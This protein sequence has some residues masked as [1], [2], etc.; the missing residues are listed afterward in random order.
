MS[1]ATPKSKPG[2]SSYSGT[3]KTSSELLRELEELSE[4]T[5]ARRAIRDAFYWITKCTATKDE[6]DLVANPYKPFPEEEYLRHLLLVFEQEP[7][8]FLEKSRTMMA[9]WL[10]SA[11][12]AHKMFTRPATRV[13]FQSQDEDR[14]IH[15]VEYVKELW[16]NSLGALKQKWGHKHRNIDEPYNRFDLENGSSCVGIPGNPGRIR[17]EHPT[18]VVLDEAAHIVMGEESYNVS[19]ATKA[20]HVIALSSAN[21]G[22]FREMTEFAKPVDWPEYRGAG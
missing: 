20:P 2:T 15:D 10:V 18:I 12:A 3:P 14:A 19:V 4:E 9:S 16:K 6:Q 13:V 22:W 21:P 5:R 11:W 7:V 8:L 1:L 17:S